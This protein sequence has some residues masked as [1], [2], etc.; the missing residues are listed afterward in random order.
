MPM[1]LLVA[2]FLNL[3]SE[4]ILCEKDMQNRLIISVIGG[5]N[6]TPEVEQTPHKLGKN[7][8]KVGGKSHK[9]YKKHLLSGK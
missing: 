7:I 9:L 3:F 5:H 4:Q 6:C 1:I 8:A 2:L